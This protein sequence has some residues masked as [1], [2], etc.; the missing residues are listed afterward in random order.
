MIQENIHFCL[1]YR[2]GGDARFNLAEPRTHR[3]RGSS[4]GDLRS[5]PAGSFGVPM[6]SVRT[7]PGKVWSLRL[8]AELRSPRNVAA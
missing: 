4:G 1:L 8:V 6:L 7:R 2:P 3:P 5:E